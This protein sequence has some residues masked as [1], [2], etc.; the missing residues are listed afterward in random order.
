MASWEAKLNVLRD[1]YMRFA[2]EYGRDVR[3]E[4]AR[5]S[6]RVDAGLNRLLDGSFGRCTL[7]QGDI[8][9]DQ[10]DADP[11]TPFYGDCYKEV[12]RLPQQPN[13]LPPVTA[14]ARATRRS[15]RTR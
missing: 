2:H 4:M 10:L 8:G 3:R 11:A 12:T 14:A 1:E 13:K 15:S 7:C 5:L 6:R 9:T